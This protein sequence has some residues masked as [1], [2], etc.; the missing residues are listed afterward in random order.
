M[1]QEMK[2]RQLVRQQVAWAYLLVFYL[3]AIWKWLEGGWLYQYEPFVFQTRMDGTT[4]VLMRSGFHQWMIRF[5]GFYLAADLFFYAMPV[6]WYIVDRRW[7]RRS[8]LLAWLM[9]LVN[10]IYVQAFTLYPTNSIEGHFA[11][12]MMPL[13]FVMRD[14]KGF[15]LMFNGL[16]YVFLFVFF[17]AGFWKIY[18]GGVFNLEQLSGILTF[19]HSHFLALSP[20]AFY[21]QWLGWLINHPMVGWGLYIVATL[22]ELMFVVGFFTKKWDRWLLLLFVLFLVFDQL[23]MSIAYYE[24]VPML[25]LLYYASMEQRQKDA[26]CPLTVILP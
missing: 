5:P 26:N 10:W 19:Q 18:W 24:M 22:I 12:L 3:L 15:S 1:G 17:S 9:L 4:W 20:D 6:L 25:I 13:L 2:S 14:Q 8:W 23:V 7:P 21:T 16:R 11:W